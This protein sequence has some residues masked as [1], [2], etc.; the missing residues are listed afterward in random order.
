MTVEFNETVYQNKS[1]ILMFPDHYV[2]MAQ[3]FEKDH[4]LAVTEN[5]RKIV[6]AGTLYPANDATAI[7]VV[8]RDLDVTDGDKNGAVI[9]HGYIKTDKLPNAPT[10]NAIAALNQITFLPIGKSIIS[11]ASATPAVDATGAVIVVD[12][13]GTDFIAGVETETNWTIGAG[14][15][16]LTLS[17]AVKTDNNKATLTFTGTVAAGTLEI[18]AKA[19]CVANGVA[20]NK[21]S[22][23]IA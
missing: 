3:K 17:T 13:I 14:T 4:S 18:T 10:A 5:G 6:K 9:L 1:E 21:I 23:V 2:A 7:G 12:L 22:I 16:G 11:T 15:T 8:F 20:S 19:A